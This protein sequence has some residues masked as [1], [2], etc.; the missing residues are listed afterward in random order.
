[1]IQPG[2]TEQP[3]QEDC[4]KRLLTSI[5]DKLRVLRNAELK[6]QE[7]LVQRISQN[8]VISANSNFTTPGID[9]HRGFNR[10]RLE[11]SASFAIGANGGIGIDMIWGN[12]PVVKI[13]DI[14]CSN[15]AASYKSEPIDIN[16]YSGFSFQLTNRDLSNSATIGSVRIEFYNE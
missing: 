5:N 16:H 1:M 12:S 8:V 3:V 15:G 11:V 4:V 9:N 7:T 2:V 10:C 13:S 14:L 6:S